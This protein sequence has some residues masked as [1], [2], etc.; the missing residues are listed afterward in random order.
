MNRVYNTES[1]KYR[2][3]LFYKSL[4]KITIFDNM[5]LQANKKQEVK[6]LNKGDRKWL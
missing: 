5:Q 4:S 3:Y 2:F 1:Q 6:K